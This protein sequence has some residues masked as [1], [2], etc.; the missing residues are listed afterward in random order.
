VDQRLARRWGKGNSNKESPR[1][2][3]NYTATVDQEQ[4][5][6]VPL[7]ITEG[8]P[9]CCEILF[10]SLCGGEGNGIL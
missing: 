7:V 4:D 2:D 5:T 9:G 8:T 10:S 6:T 1:Q 3:I